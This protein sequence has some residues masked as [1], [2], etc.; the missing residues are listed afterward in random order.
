MIK[1]I[2]F[3]FN[4]TIL[5]DA[6]LCY[7]IERIMFKDIG[8]TLFDF[9]DYKD[10]FI[11]PVSA[12]YELLGIK[13]EE[14]NYDELNKIFFDEYKK[15]YLKEAKVFP[16][17]KETFMYLKN[18]GYN[19]YILSATEIN[20]LKEQLKYYGIDQFFDEL[21]ASN[22]IDGKGKIE[23]GKEF[24]DSHHFDKTNTLLIGDTDHD[25]ETAIALNINIL[26]FAS[27]HNS[28]NRLS[29]LTKNIVSSYL[30]IRDYIEEMNEKES[31]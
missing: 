8:L 7:D 5:D 28:Y 17:A 10:N 4:G 31:K 23:Y 15:R 27:G 19:L 18:R 26:M 12:Y 29:K 14:H 24:V 20:T 1:N 21:V 25:Y 13:N 3:D 2:I 30:E 16:N 6:Y 22:K 9:N 11:H